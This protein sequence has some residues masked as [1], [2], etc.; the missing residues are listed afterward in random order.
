MY[1]KLTDSASKTSAYPPMAYNPTHPK[2]MIRIHTPIPIPTHSVIIGSKGQH[3]INEEKEDED[4]KEVEMIKMD[5]L[6]KLKGKG[7]WTREEKVRFWKMF[8][9]YV[10]YMSACVWVINL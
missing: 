4:A 6:V 8:I 7:K 2:A 10:T 1:L 3:A 9:P 5:K